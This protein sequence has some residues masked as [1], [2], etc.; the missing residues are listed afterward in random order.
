MTLPASVNTK[1]V[2]R[3]TW[4]PTVQGEVSRALADEML[5]V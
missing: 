3:E 5:C 4:Q 2:G 1:E